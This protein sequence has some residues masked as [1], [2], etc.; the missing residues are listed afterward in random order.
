MNRITRWIINQWYALTGIQIPI[1]P[2][3]ATKE[4]MKTLIDV[5]FQ[6]GGPCPEGLPP[7]DPGGPLL[8][9]VEFIFN[10]GP[11]VTSPA[12]FFEDRENN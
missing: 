7:E 12:S 5:K 3:G 8:P 4:K 1:P 11:P 9:A 10:E 6:P 2:D